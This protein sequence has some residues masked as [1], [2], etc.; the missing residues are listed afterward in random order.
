MCSNFLQQLEIDALEQLIS[1]EVKVQGQIVCNGFRT[2]LLVFRIVAGVVAIVVVR[3]VAGVV[4][5]VVVGVIIGE[6][7]IYHHSSTHVFAGGV[8]AHLNA[9]AVLLPSC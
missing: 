1:E 2:C 8:R 9:R 6:D 3:V 5:G 7:E 4:D